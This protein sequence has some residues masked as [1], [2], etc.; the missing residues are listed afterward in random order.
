[1]SFNEHDQDLL[2]TYLKRIFDAVASGTFAPDAARGNVAD[3]VKLVA[4]G[5]D[6]RDYMRAVIHSGPFE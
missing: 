6:Y 5:G 4:G 2:D 3:L 1:M